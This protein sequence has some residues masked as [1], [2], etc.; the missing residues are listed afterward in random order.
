M[1][2]SA[3]IA[4]YNRTMLSKMNPEDAARRDK[5][6]EAFK[7]FDMESLKETAK[8]AYHHVA[9]L[10]NQMATYE[11]DLALTRRVI[12]ERLLAEKR[13]VVNDPSFD[14]R[15]EYGKPPTAIKDDVGLYDAL[16]SLVIDGEPLPAEVLAKAAW[17]E[18]PPPPA[19]IK[20]TDLSKIKTLVK[21]YGDAVGAIIEKFVTRPPASARLVLE[22]KENLYGEPRTDADGND[23][24][25]L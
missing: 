20:K 5:K 16:H 4:W 19:P 8:V 17:I 3:R 12:L 11:E 6:Y 15:I 13:A 14:I 23:D 7:T 9:R 24:L 10:R 25:I 22:P 1:L 18:T 2:I 21:D